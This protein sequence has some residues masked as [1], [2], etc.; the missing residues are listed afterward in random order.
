MQL[1]RSTP[2]MSERSRRLVLPPA[3]RPAS[4]VRLPL[5][6]GYRIQRLHQSDEGYETPVLAAAVSRDRLFETFLDLLEPLGPV[7]DVVIE[8]S[9][10]STNGRHIDWYREGIDLP[11]LQSGLLEYEEFLLSDGCTGV[12]VVDA[13]QGIEVQFDEHTLLVVYA[14]SLRPFRRGLEAADVHEDRGLRLVTDAEHLHVTRPEFAETFERLCSDLGI[15]VP[16][17]RS[18]ESGVRD[19][20][21][22][23]S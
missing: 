23:W 4:G 14:S 7:V 8:S 13:E 16:G 6:E 20:E 5:S 21:L 11:V 9:H 12:A 19:Q 10:D 18:Q 17:V 1:R 2:R 3:I 15:L 22:G